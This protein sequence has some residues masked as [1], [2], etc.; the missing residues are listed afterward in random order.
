MST[1]DTLLAQRGWQM[2]GWT[3]VYFV[4]QGAAVAALYTCAEWLLRRSSAAARYAAGCSALLMML[5]CPVA[6]FLWL[7]AASAARV[8]VQ[9]ATLNNM[10]AHDAPGATT[11]THAPPAALTDQPAELFLNS[12]DANAPLRVW[13][14]ERFALALP[15][16]AL[17]WLMGACLLSL[18]LAG[19]WLVAQRLKR[20]PAPLC[21]RAWQET[22]AR[23]VRRLRVSRPVRLCASALVEVPTVVG[24]LRPVI[25]MPLCALTSLSAPQLEALIAHELAHIRRYDYLV[26]LLQSVIETLLFYHPAVWWLSQ[27]VRAEREHCCDDLAV[28][29]TGDVLAY[30]RALTMLEHLRRRTGVSLVVA[31]DG[32]VLM[33]RIERLLRPQPVVARRAPLSAAL[34]VAL[35]TLACVFAGA[36]TFTTYSR[37][38]APERQQPAPVQTKRKVAVTF[39]SM[40]AFQTYYNPRAERD[41]RKL[42]GSLRAHNAPA[43]GFVGENTLYKNGQLDEE[44]VQLLRTWLDAGFELGTQTFS[45]PS[46]YKTSLYQFELNV[47]RGEEVTSKLLNERGQRLRYFSYPYLNTGPDR[48][49]KEA[50]EKFLAERGYRI[51]QI[52]IDNMDWLFARVYAEA[53][54]N[55]DAETMK[56]VAD[57][58]VPYMERMLAFYEQLARD[59]LGYEP[60]QVMLLMASALNADK[61]DELIAMMARR[62]YQFVTLDEAQ[63]DPAYSLPDTYTGPVGISWL[64]R[65]AMTRGA[66][67]RKEPDLP[68]YMQQYDF[69]QSGSDFKTNKQ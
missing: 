50:C 19:G 20:E 2:L 46:L 52:T 9:T 24:T 4:W 12:S 32:G 23:L 66:S 1:L 28:Q 53:R 25:L 63:S 16:L 35:V 59:T 15:W 27:R 39:V 44:R 68:A 47:R 64:Q 11:Q 33:Q 56:R 26:N 34:A 58:Y 69:R 6:T 40:P 41:L 48:A 38:D 13:A 30:A 54:R 62:G 36:Q 21:E 60:P 65:W 14:A 57:E 29:A 17:A 7:N 37:Y 43:I 31:A 18:R 3:L 8:P 61:M 22:L 49:T 67:F 51:H 45:H 42:I 10:P 5:A 55:D